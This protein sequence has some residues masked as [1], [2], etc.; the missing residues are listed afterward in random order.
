MDTMENGVRW[1]EE[2]KARVPTDL[3]AE[4]E[5]VAKRKMIS[6]SDLLRIA[7]SEYVV[8]NPIPHWGKKRISAVRGVEAV[9]TG[10]PRLKR[11]RKSRPE[12]AS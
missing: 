5:C 12:K 8:R 6:V 9:P 1:T 11:G 10:E 2:I 4:V 7:L 3:K